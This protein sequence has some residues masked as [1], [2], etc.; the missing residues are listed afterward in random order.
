MCASSIVDLGKLKN[1]EI[2]IVQ[3]DSRPLKGYWRVAAE[4]NHH[5]AAIH[6]H[7]FAYYS[8]KPGQKCKH[9]EEPLASPWCKVL[10]MLQ[11]DRDLP[12]AK[13]LLYMDSDAVVNKRFKNTPL[14]QFLELMQSR[15]AWDP[16]ARPLVFNQ[17]GKCWWCALI[18]RVGYGVCLNAGTVLWYRHPTSVRLLRAWWDSSMDEQ[19]EGNPIRR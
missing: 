10:S 2:A 14:P 8:T 13:V 18:E 5:Y 1:E 3:F 4:W 6:N 11:A 9:D 16:E 15:L 12:H 7:S 19:L 17:D